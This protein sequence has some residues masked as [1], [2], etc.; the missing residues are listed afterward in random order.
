MLGAACF[1]ASFTRALKVAAAV[2]IEV[3]SC[4][5]PATR[6]G[7]GD[8]R[9]VSTRLGRRAGSTGSAA[10]AAGRI[11]VALLSNAGRAAATR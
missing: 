7:R 10:G 6:G 2:F 9:A 8:A 3:T 11:R 1:D 5:R 4:S